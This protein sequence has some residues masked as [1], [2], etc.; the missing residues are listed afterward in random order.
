M[1]YI[2]TKI[3]EAYFDA[4]TANGIATSI[5]LDCLPPKPPPIL[6]TLQYT[7]LDLIPNVLATNVC[8]SEAP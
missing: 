7:R 3:F 5:L 6:L 2:F 1:F 4:A 8:K